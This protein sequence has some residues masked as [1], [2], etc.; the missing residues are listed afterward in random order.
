[1]IETRKIKGEPFNLS[2]YFQK[3]VELQDIYSNPYTFLFKGRR[4]FHSTIGMFISL[5]VNI[6]GFLFA[7]FFFL[8]INSHNSPNIVDSLFKGEIPL[9]ITLNSG[10]Y[11]YLFSLVDKNNSQIFDSSIATIEASYEVTSMLPNGTFTYNQFPIKLENCSN[12]INND[13]SEYEYITKSVILNNYYCFNKT[14]SGIELKLGGSQGDEFRS[15]II[16]NIKKCNNNFCKYN[17]NEEIQNSAFHLI[18]LSSYIDSL[19]YKNPIKYFV[20]KERIQFDPDF[21]KIIYHNFHQ[22]NYTS[23]NNL[24]FD[25]TEEKTSITFDNIEKEIFIPNHIYKNQNEP[26]LS[27]II[28]QSQIKEVFTRH[29]TKLQDITASMGGLW[30][31]LSLVGTL[32]CSYYKRREF[33]FE[34]SN[35]FFTFVPEKDKENTFFKMVKK[36]E[37]KFFGSFISGKKLD[38]NEPK[39]GGHK[40]L[41]FQKPNIEIP[42]CRTNALRIRPFKKN[43]NNRN[44]L[45]L[46]NKGKGNGSQ[47]DVSSVAKSNFNLLS[48]ELKK[49][50][51]FF[52]AQFSQFNHSNEVKRGSLIQSYLKYKEPTKKKKTFHPNVNS[53][54]ISQ[55]LVCGHNNKLKFSYWYFTQILFC[56]CTKNGKELK[57]EFQKIH[58]TL[59]QYADL[60]EVG[61]VF[62]DVE[63]IKNRL[64]EMQL[65]D[66]RKAGKKIIYLNGDL[67]D[68]NLK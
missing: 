17:L 28:N 40:K 55:S 13:N 48:P 23:D 24:V 44:S 29:Y 58:K 65:L 34:L 37:L 32:L 67:L 36:T 26:L 30:S 3:I 8:K 19:D 63:V 42:K 2:N 35:A 57:V 12:F 14:T 18:Y 41:D 50:S 43:K 46:E 66:R 64:I 6:S 47:I 59:S 56:P 68:Q 9:N 45:V 25:T 49:R 21:H 60:A 61:K 7:V 16:I 1:M 22:I 11:F 31:T 27:L 39:K 15:R 33:E 10:K 62:M 53:I 20:K 52:R 51:S 38:K 4:A 54:I 5:I